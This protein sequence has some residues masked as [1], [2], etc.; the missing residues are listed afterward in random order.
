MNF[1]MSLK[2]LDRYMGEF[3]GRHNRSD[4][5]TMDQIV[6]MVRGMESK[7]LRYKALAGT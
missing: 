4:P 6:A 2:H 7:R 1:S 5:D 3:G